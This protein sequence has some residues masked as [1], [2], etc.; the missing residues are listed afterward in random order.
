[1]E[2]PRLNGAIRALESGSPA[3]ATFTP[4]RSA[5]PQH[6]R[7]GLRRGG[8][9]DGAQSLRHHRAQALPAVHAE[10][11]ADRHRR[12]RRAGGDAHACAFR[13]MAASKASGW[14]SRCWTSGFT[15]SFGRT[16]ARWRTRATRSPRAR[17]PRPPEAPYYEPAGQRGDAPTNAARYWGLTGPEYYSGPTPGR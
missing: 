8:V 7:G 15:A 10:P 13:R 11:P 2:I 5:A 4:P 3:F 6:R 17:Y 14:P 1:M 12:Q 16:S 9:R